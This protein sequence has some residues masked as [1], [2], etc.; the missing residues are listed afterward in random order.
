M[1]TKAV[2]V[3]GAA[4]MTV[5]RTVLPDSDDR[6]T[7]KI[8]AMPGER[9]VVINRFMSADERAFLLGMLGVKRT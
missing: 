1:G 7:E 3:Y 4:D 9:A 5:R 6:A 8:Q 2:I